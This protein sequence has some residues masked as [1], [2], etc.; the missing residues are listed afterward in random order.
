MRNARLFL[1]PPPLLGL[2]RRSAPLSLSSL[3]LTTQFAAQTTLEDDE[4]EDVVSD[5]SRDGRKKK[6]NPFIFQ[7]YASF[8]TTLL[9]RFK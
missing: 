5:G 1:F 9:S 3:P 4:E 8:D 2:F 6:K 7:Q